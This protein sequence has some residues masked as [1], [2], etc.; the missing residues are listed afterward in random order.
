MRHI[1]KTKKE[2]ILIIV[3]LIV[4]IFSYI[5]YFVL[6][7]PNNILLVAICT[8]DVILFFLNAYTISSCFD[9]SK[10]LTVIISIVIM[11]GFVLIFEAIV[12]LA[13]IDSDKVVFT[14]DL[15]LKVFLIALFASPSLIILLP[16]LY[17]VGEALS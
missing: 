3:G 8:I 10:I 15:F 6:K 4:T 9:K 17:I 13:T 7:N 14:F 1:I 16:V 12:A 2:L 11:I 5:Y